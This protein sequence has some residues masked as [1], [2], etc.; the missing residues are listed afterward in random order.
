M[1][2][3]P[4]LTYLVAFADPLEAVRPETLF[5]KRLWHSCFPVNFAKILKTRFLQNT[6]GRLLLNNM[7]ATSMFSSNTKISYCYTHL[8]YGF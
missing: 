8:H 4:R 6:S 5:K 1:A 2:Y 3:F 7:I